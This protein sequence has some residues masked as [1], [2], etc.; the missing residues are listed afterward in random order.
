MQVHL[1]CDDSQQQQL[2]KEVRKTCNMIVG[3]FSKEL[4]EGDNL[5]PKT[6]QSTGDIYIY[7]YTYIDIYR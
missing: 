2:L 4:W 1:W 5:W 3:I 6:K 7:I